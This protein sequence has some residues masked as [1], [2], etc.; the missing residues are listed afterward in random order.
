MEQD[1]ERPLLDGRATDIYGV[2]VML[3][4]ISSCFWNYYDAKDARG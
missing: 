2:R 4:I 3:S 1:Y